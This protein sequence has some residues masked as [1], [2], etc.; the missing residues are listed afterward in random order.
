MLEV[1]FDGPT[2]V[3]IVGDVSGMAVLMASTDPDAIDCPMVEQ[4]TRPARALQ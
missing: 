1:T 2:C 3:E 4:W